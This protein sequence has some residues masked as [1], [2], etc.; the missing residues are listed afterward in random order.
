R[1]ADG[2]QR[3]GGAGVARGAVAAARTG[4]RVRAR[5]RAWRAR[6]LRSDPARAA[7]A[8]ARELGR[9]V[10]RGRARGSAHAGGD[11]RR[12]GDRAPARAREARTP[13]DALGVAHD[14]GAPNCWFKAR[15]TSSTFTYFSP[16]RPSQGAA[17]CESRMASI[18]LRTWAGFRPRA[19][20]HLPAT[21][22]SWYSALSSVMCGSSPEPDA[23]TMS[24]GT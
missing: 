14:R 17:V 21:R 19:A 3:I 7:R 20:A 13:G 23:I 6:A 15:F 8:L 2:G 5:R 18:C 1:E 16:A 11:L 9:A 24:A 4:R 10:A 12:R 22:S